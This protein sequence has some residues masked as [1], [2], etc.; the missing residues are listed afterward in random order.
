MSVG[1]GSPMARTKF[2]PVSIAVTVASAL[3]LVSCGSGTSGGADT[4]LLLQKN[5]ALGV[6]EGQTG[7][8]IK[9]VHSGAV[10]NIVIDDTGRLFGWGTNVCGQ[11]RF[12]ALKGG[13]TKFVTVASG[14]DHALALDNLGQLYAWGCNAMGQ[15][16]IPALRPG[17]TKFV[18]V[19][20]GL[21]HGLAID[22][23]GQAY[24]WGLNR[25]GQVNIP[26]LKGGATKFVAVA[27]GTMHSLA[28]D[29]LGQMYA[30][31]GNPHGQT[32]I[33]SLRG[34]AA[35]F[36]R[37]AAAELH[38]VALD[39]LGQYYG[40]GANTNGQLNPPALT[41]GGTKLVAVS[42]MNLPVV[43]IDDK[44]NAYDWG[45]NSSRPPA[46]KPGGTRFVSISASMSHATAADDAG[47]MYAWGNNFYGYTN[48]PESFSMK[49]PKMP[50]AMGG[51]QAYGIEDTGTV[52]KFDSGPDGHSPDETGPF[53]YVAAGARHALAVTADGRVVA[54]GESTAGQTDVPEGLSNVVE[55]AAGYAYSV[56]LRADGKVVEWGSHV[57]QARTMVAMPADLPALARIRGGMRHVLGITRTGTVVGWGDNRWGQATPPAGLSGVV[58]V[59]ALWDCSAALKSDGTITYWGACLK[60]FTATSS[61]PGAK[62]LVMTD[63]AVIALKSDGSLTAWGV[64]PGHPVMK[65]PAGKDFAAVSAGFDAALAVTKTG[66]V[67]AWGDNGGHAITIPVGFGGVAPQD[68]KVC[69][70]C[71]D[72][73]EKF[74][75]T[76]AEIDEIAA[77][78]YAMLTP[79][80]RDRFIR[81]LGG[82]PGKAVT[83][84]EIDALVKAASAE[85]KAAATSV[86][87]AAQ[88]PDPVENR[89]VVLP[90]AQDP[91]TKVGT[92]VT[93]AQAARILGLGKVSKVGF[94]VPKKA[95]A[96]CTVTKTKVT[97]S[98]K[99]TCSVT[100]RYTKAKKAK[101][102]TLTLVV[103]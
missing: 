16:N 19:A 36:V 33:P 1:Y 101:K 6:V 62:S 97:A 88:A 72:D 65:V 83:Q 23:A 20:S 78:W 91:V 34:G 50:I 46:L 92:V 9:S 64:D 58:A 94:V 40:F 41:G 32:N 24:G 49:V 25:Y 55:V 26:A 85:Q 54:W 63:Q 51:H 2:S 61:V 80:Q 99:G 76:D 93:T 43:A 57:G 13:A 18:A 86:V 102:A 53:N 35:R 68:G 73:A 14:Q 3:A 17:G 100:V 38:S 90:A 45:G 87:T 4:T 75:P 52:S 21:F 12:P 59:A 8:N 81:A 44:G 39:D 89:A 11:L 96:S 74:A 10:F 69:D 30:F 37:I 70:D 71:N 22:D 31:G 84:S 48:I 47:N 95:G 5:A 103:G 67:V 66:T 28:L 79:E 98:V 27:G 15:T 60:E 7:L 82:T 42:T 29:N 56:A 77:N